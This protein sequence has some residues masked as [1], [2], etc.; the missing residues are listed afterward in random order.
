MP[1]A[2]S[3]IR[4]SQTKGKLSLTHR[5]IHCDCTEGRRDKGCISSRQASRSCFWPR[6]IAW[7]PKLTAVHTKIIGCQHS[8]PRAPADVLVVGPGGSYNDNLRLLA[9]FVEVFRGIDRKEYRLRLALVGT[10]FFVI[11]LDHPNI[12]VGR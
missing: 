11:E 9:V 2:Q 5:N 8:S 7:R 10:V 12:A 1:L 6:M 4:P 3:L